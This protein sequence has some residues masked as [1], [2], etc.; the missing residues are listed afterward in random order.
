MEVTIVKGTTGGKIFNANW[1]E[2]KYDDVTGTSVEH[3]RGVDGDGKFTFKR[4]NKDDEKVIVDG[5]IV[6]R[7]YANFVAAD[8]V[9]KVDG[10]QLNEKQFEAHSGS[11]IIVLKKDYLDSLS[12]G[13]H[14]LSVD[15]LDGGR[16]F[17][18]TTKFYIRM[19][20]ADTNSH[21]IPTTGIQSESEGGNFYRTISMFAILAL[22]AT[23]KLRN[24]VG[25]DYWD[26]FK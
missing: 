21:V 17:T 3:V 10:K 12:I 15:F 19:K 24:K 25:K 5:V 1:Q 16:L 11:L 13:E 2:I 4:N 8:R 26:E 14:K 7:T 22:G 23:I 6:S 18:V 20:P 9:V